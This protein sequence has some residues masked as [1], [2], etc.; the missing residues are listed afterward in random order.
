MDYNSPK[1]VF[2][3]RFVYSGTYAGPSPFA[4]FVPHFPA[5]PEDYR[6]Q[7]IQREANTNRHYVV[8]KNDATE[9]LYVEFVNLGED[10]SDE[11]F[12]LVGL[13]VTPAGV[14]NTS[15]FVASYYTLPHFNKDD[16]TW[17]DNFGFVNGLA[18]NRRD[19]QFEKIMFTDHSGITMGWGARHGR[20][21]VAVALL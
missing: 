10:R 14:S 11:V 16:N 19:L 3:S 18:G 4:A 13:Q 20:P 2:K 15:W 12:E 5:N 17:L 1:P 9:K 8:N 21:V 7:I 6:A